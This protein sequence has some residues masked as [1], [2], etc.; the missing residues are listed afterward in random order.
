MTNQTI[1]STDFT[2]GSKKNHARIMLWIIAWMATFV[3]ADKAE[4]YEWYTS[5]LLSALAIVV[6][7][8]IG[9]GVIVTYMKFLK[10]L[11][12]L[13]QKIQLNALALAM[14]VGY[15]GSF[16]YSLMVT[17]GF[18]TDPELTIIIMLMSGTYSVALVAGR[19]R[20]R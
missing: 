16:I 8:A 3:A 10:E 5:D 9:V 4:L 15:V 12:E 11:D 19:V 1:N 13:Q 20:Y 17:A 2:V 18:V 7:A 14:G 6:N